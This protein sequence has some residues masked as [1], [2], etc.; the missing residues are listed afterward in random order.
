[1]SSFCRRLVLLAVFAAAL[2][3]AAAVS[4]AEIPVSGVLRTVAG[5][6]VADGAYVFLLK[7]YDAKDAQVFIWDDAVPG[8]QVQSGFFNLQVGST[9]GKPLADAVLTAGKPLW[10]G[11]QVGS[12]PELPRQQLL[13]VPRAYFAN[14]AAAGSFGYAAA[15]SPGGAATGLACSG[16]VASDMLA[17]G[18]VT[19]LKV[20]FNYAASDSKGGSALEA[21]HAANADAAKVAEL[22]KNANN[23]TS[24]D[25]ANSLKC[26]GC[27]ALKMLNADVAGGYLSTTAGGKVVGDVGVSGKV[28]VGGD[29]ALIGNLALTTASTISGGKFEALDLTKVACDVNALGR[30]AIGT[31]KKRLYFCDGALWQRL[32]IC[33][34]KCPLA[35]TV[36]C[37]QDIVND[38]GE[39]QCVGTGTF[40]NNGAQCSNGLC[41]GPGQSKETAGKTCQT[42]LTTNPGLKSD[43]YWLDPDGVNVGVDAFQVYCNMTLEGGGWAQVGR[44]NLNALGAVTNTGVLWRADNDVNLGY[45]ISAD[46]DTVYDAGHLSVA[47]VTALANAGEKKIMNFVKKHSTQEFKYC[48]NNY[49]AGPDGNW[50]FVSGNSGNAG[51]GSCGKLGWGYGATCGATSTSC[52]SND[53]NYTMDGHWMH[54]NGLNS[55]TLGGIVQ[56]YCGDNS[57]SGIGSSNA[58]TGDRRG[59]CYLYVR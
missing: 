20:G 34:E 40:C 28:S 5:G 8:V 17:N 57:T 23:A 3:F 30:V 16:C 25:E 18:A 1:M 6:P 54:A 49:A 22:A 12:D 38:C 37:G 31:A 21:V 36:A 4:A 19:A 11:V 27:V 41:A 58:A 45:L 55:G 59:T 51:K 10:I 42:L 53:A 2:P 33:S 32:T 9:L 14:M 29:L 15:D 50:S 35:A 7:L 47:R 43:V 48:W 56:T 46:N 39:A 24:A 44:F 52:Q 26:S 13:S